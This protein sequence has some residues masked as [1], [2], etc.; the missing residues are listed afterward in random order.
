MSTTGWILLIVGI[1]VLIVI[2][3]LV[4]KAAGRAKVAQ[5]ERDRGRASALRDAGTQ[6]D[7]AAKA[8][9]AE[10]AEAKA[11]ADKARVEAERL[12]REA[13]DRDSKAADTRGRAD[14]HLRAADQIDPDRDVDTH[15]RSQSPGR[16]DG[17]VPPEGSG[18]P[19]R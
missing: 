8:D 7:L 5:Q 12:E 17:D 19:R 4:V 15:D 1:I 16:S 11:K 6:S 18:P 9:K 14:E 2:I 13:A 3:A 10:A